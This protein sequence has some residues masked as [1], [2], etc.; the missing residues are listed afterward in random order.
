MGKARDLK[1]G[2]VLQV[3]GRVGRTHTVLA[4]RLIVLTGYV[5]L[6]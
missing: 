6:A 3:I 4:A 1:P 2:A 5:N